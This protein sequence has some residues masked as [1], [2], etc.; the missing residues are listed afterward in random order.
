MNGH[1]DEALEDS[2]PVGKNLSLSHAPK[3][4]CRSARAPAWKENNRLALRFAGRE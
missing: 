2:E 3:S 4:V 1:F